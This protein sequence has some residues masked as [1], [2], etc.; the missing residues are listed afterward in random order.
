L[1][2]INVGSSLIT[3]GADGTIRCSLLSKNFLKDSLISLAVIIFYFFCLFSKCQL[4]TDA[5]NQ[6]AKLHFLLITLG[7]TLLFY[8]SLH[9]KLYLMSKIL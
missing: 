6:L 7:V 4:W 1:V 3:I 9:T 2:N 8:I 5:P